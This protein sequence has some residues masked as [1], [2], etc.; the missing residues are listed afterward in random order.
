MF[1]K[2]IALVSV[3][4]ITAGTAHAACEI[5]GNVSIVGNEFPAIQTV[6]KGA[7]ACSGGEVKSNLT[8][9][10]QKI[11]VDGMS[12]N[13]AEYSSAIIANSSIVALMNEDVIRPLNDLVAEYGQDIPKNQLITIDGNIMA[14]AFMANAQTLAYRKDVLAEIGADVPSS[15]EDVLA[16]AE[17][18]RAA[19]ISQYPVGG[20]YKAGWNLAQEFTNMYIGH[21]GEFYNAG[22]AEVAINNA[23]GVATLNMLKKL[24]EYMNPD[25]L[26]HDS[27]ATGAEMEAGN[28]VIM[29]M[30]GS[31]MGSL[32]DAEGAE[33]QV[34][35]NITV[36]GPLTVAGGTT[37]A[38][39]LWWD[40]WTVAKNISDEDAVATFLAMKHGTS[41]A[42]LNDE[43]MSQ[44]VWMIEGYTPAPVNDGVFAAI[45]AGTISYPMLPYHGLLHTA[46]GNNISDFLLGKESAEQALADTEAAYTAAAKEKG[47]LN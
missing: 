17:K 3:L 19:G 44:A 39:T 11:N 47:F 34:Y 28:V 23:Q 45:A 1:F 16:A 14:V 13:P 42:I 35:S 27:N 33:E 25:F 7:A 8:A 38:S 43:T 2:K 24:T 36:G 18:I 10:H 32:M 6:A 41:P 20:A 40:G 21:G 46:L 30:W 31:R 15:Y 9:D 37:P 22:T 12:G 29:N 4:A 5:S 26:T